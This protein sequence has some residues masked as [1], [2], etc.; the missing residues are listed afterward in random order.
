MNNYYYLSHG[1]PGSGRYPLGSGERPY[2]KFER[3]GRRSSGGISGYI[4]ARKAK[5]AEAEQIK[6]QNQKRAAEEAKRQHDANKEQ[7]LRSG[8]A[9]DVLKY[10]GELTNQQLQEAIN[11]LNSEA[12]LRSM[13]QKETVSTLNKIDEIMKTIETGT[14]W[15]KI[16]T[17]SY[18]AFA[19]IY[20]ATE[21]GKKNPLTIVSTSGGGGGS[22]NKD[23]K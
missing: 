5:K 18:N 6:Q 11:R 22:K 19:A 21:D 2:Q 13:A 7:I 9:S 16:G 20:N 12:T 8:K 10:Q 1:G 15:V 23:K 14:K 3:P 4:K 17:D